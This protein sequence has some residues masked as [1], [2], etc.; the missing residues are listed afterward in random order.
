MLAHLPNR[1]NSLTRG[2]ARATSTPPEN[3]Y[4]GAKLFAFARFAFARW[5]VC[6]SPR[7]VVSRD[8][9]GASVLLRL[10]LCT[11]T[12]IACTRAAVSPNASAPL[13]PHGPFITPNFRKL[14]STTTT[15]RRNELRRCRNS[16]EYRVHGIEIEN[17]TVCRHERVARLSARLRIPIFP[18][19]ECLF[20]ESR[21]RNRSSRSLLLPHSRHELKLSRSVFIKLRVH[22]TRSL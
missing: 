11:R 18:S 8:A 13:P 9:A 20:S 3:H 22:Q 14:A 12:T 21:R 16:V 15:R 1:F 4:N 7:R 10:S 5:R 19:K 2:H 17:Y 6:T